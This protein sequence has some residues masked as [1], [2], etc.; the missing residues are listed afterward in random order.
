VHDVETP[1]LVMLFGHDLT[2]IERAFR[3]SPAALDRIVTNRRNPTTNSG[4]ILEGGPGIEDITSVIKA[5]P[6]SSRGTGI[7]L[8]SNPS[9]P[10]KDVTGVSYEYPPMYANRMVSGAAF[11]YYRSGDR[12]GNPRYFGTGTIGDSRPSAS[13]TGW[14]ECDILDYRAFES[15]IPFR[16]TDGRYLEPGGSRRGYYQQGCRRVPIEVIEEVRSA[17]S[18]TDDEASVVA[19]S[20]AAADKKYVSSEL[21]RKID[22]Y[23]MDAA[24]VEAVKRYPGAV[25]VRMPHNNPGYDIRVERG[26]NVVRYIEVKGTAGTDGAFFI[27]EGERKFS[28]D[29]SNMYSLLVVREVDLDNKTHKTSWHNGPVSLAVFS[30]KVRQWQGLIPAS[31]LAPNEPAEGDGVSAT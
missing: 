7:V 10:Y 3:L 29:T 31:A 5:A 11:V 6:L 17:A 4:R 23:A 9:S 8:T 26:G 13:T 28:E 25:V 22:S 21:A 14:L 15:P 12:E 27:S 16:T 30:L 2:T 19:A 20:A 24:E 18:L 1:L